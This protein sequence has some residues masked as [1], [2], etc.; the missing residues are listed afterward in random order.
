VLVVSVRKS[1][2]ASEE[3][4][5]FPNRVYTRIFYGHSSNR[6]NSVVVA[7]RAYSRFLRTRPR[8]VLVGSA[9]RIVPWLV[10]LRRLGL[11]GRARLVAT[12]QVDFDDREARHVDRIIVYSHEQIRLHEPDV[13]DRYVFMPLPADG[14]FA[15]VEPP[16]DAGGYIFS[17][18]GGMRDFPSLIEA[19]RGLEARRERVTVSPDTLG[20][21]GELPPN[22][23][24]HWRM[25]VS[26]F[27]GRMAGALFVVVP[28]RA[29]PV[30]HGQ[31]SV[32]Q[33]LSLGKPVIATRNASLED[34]I[35]DGVEGLLVEPGDVE[36]YRRAIERLLGDADL[37]RAME[38]RA[39]ERARDL[40]YAGFRDRLVGLCE[41]LLA[42]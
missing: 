21:E 18:G 8:L 3:C 9:H 42:E 34:Y 4:E 19:A 23:V 36:G 22:C 38:S 39:R 28:L 14:D 35:S 12:N 11:L 24:V 16:P 5:V 40:T 41:A 32:V 27:L 31:T 2:W 13:R 33:A 29:G 26:A 10:R 17:G 20:Y 15:A 25:P 6:L 37:R 30:P 7:I 1:F